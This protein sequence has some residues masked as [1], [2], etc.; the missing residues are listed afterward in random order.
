MLDRYAMLQPIKR[1][2]SSI[3]TTSN[4]INKNP[5]ILKSLCNPTRKTIANENINDN[6]DLDQI[7]EKYKLNKKQKEAFLNSVF[8]N[9]TYLVQGPPG[10]G[11]TQV[12]SAIMHYF[13]LQNENVCISSSTHEAIS[14]CL[15]RINASTINNPNVILYKKDKHNANNSNDFS[16]KNLYKNFVQKI[17]KFSL[18][19]EQDSKKYK[20][21]HDK[22][23]TFF[24]FYKQEENKEKFSTVNFE[25]IDNLILE[26]IIA[27]KNIYKE[28]QYDQ[29]LI[30]D[31][32]NHDIKLNGRNK[33]VKRICA[34]SDL[35]DI[36]YDELLTRF[37]L[38]ENNNFNND[39][40]KIMKEDNICFLRYFDFYNYIIEKMNKKQTKNATFIK[41]MKSYYNILKFDYDENDTS[42]EKMH[43]KEEESDFIDYIFDKELIN[44]IGITT[45]G[46][47]EIKINDKSKNLL[48]EYPIYLTII[49]E[50]SKASTTEILNRV[51]SSNKL[52]LCGDYKQL[53]PSLNIDK[54]LIKEAISNILKNKKEFDRLNDFLKEYNIQIQY[55]NLNGNDNNPELEK[56]TELISDI[57]NT[58]VFEKLVQKSKNEELSIFTYLNEQHRSNKDIEKLVNNFY[59]GDEKLHSND[60]NNEMFT[61]NNDDN[62]GVYFVDTTKLASAYKDKYPFIKDDQAFDQ[63]AILNTKIF[64]EF[65]TGG[66]LFNEYNCF[67][68][69]EIINKVINENKNKDLKN[70]IGIIC[71][72]KNQKIITRRLVENNP[73]FKDLKIK[74][75]TIDNFQGR[76]NEIIIVDFVKAKNRLSENKN[77]EILDR[78]NLDFLINSKRINV[79][80]SR[81][82]SL[83]ILVGAFD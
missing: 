48:I 69:K 15:D 68:V 41:N 81:A 46:A 50:V 16:E 59:P 4:G 25:N 79:A 19:E 38:N 13:V 20:E 76:E 33:T 56:I 27:I 7:I 9:D 74:V 52:I 45:N 26:K 78:R 29:D 72:T 57:L 70:K 12:I 54:S 49:D 34:D 14:N 32:K 71:L 62:N 35:Y 6:P 58:P 37:D 18:N 10:T 31:I 61:F 24:D 60:N 47:Q 36:F 21:I 8:T 39:L 40:I 66:S 75:D 43:L 30:N 64:K 73:D 53:P 5:F 55:E 42:V 44:V 51:N 1:Y 82:K 22:Y 11:K 3:L 83:L 17:Y 63:K 2:F 80:A 28:D 77:I 23:K 67:I 65:K